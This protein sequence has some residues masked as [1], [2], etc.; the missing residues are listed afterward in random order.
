VTVHHPVPYTRNACSPTSGAYPTRAHHTRAHNAQADNAL[1]LNASAGRRGLTLIE[2]LVVL[3]VLALLVGLVAPQIF[4]RIGE[5]RS[6]TASTQIRL[7]ETALDNYRLDAGN[8]PS[9]EQG[10]AALRER[11]SR[12][13]LPLAWKGPYLRDDVPNDPWG[14]GYVYHADGTG[15][16]FQLYS[17]GKDGKEGGDGEDADIGR[18]TGR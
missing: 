18:K 7:L 6:T 10:L 12:P 14:R 11:P 4:G 17:L 2:L 16:A 8:F 5:A 13:P 3:V 15:S 1:A 9:T